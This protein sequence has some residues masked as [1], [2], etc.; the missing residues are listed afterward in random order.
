MNEQQFYLDLDDNEGTRILLLPKVAKPL[1]NR[2]Y[3]PHWEWDDGG[4]V[5]VFG[6]FEEVLQ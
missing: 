2:G 4:S 1:V 3:K 6:P 5:L